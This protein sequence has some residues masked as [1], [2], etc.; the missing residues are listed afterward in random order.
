MTEI[1]FR[2]AE[3]TDREAILSLNA[4]AFGRR[5]E[6]DIV[7]RLEDGGDALLQLVA[8]MEGDVVG[9]ILFYAIRIDGRVCA[10]GLGP[11]SVNPWAQ[12]S[13]IGTA[14]VHYG[15]R[16]LQDGGVCVVF[17]LGHEAYYPRF[18][19]SELAAAPFSAPW[20]G[21][22]FMAVRLR[23]GPPVAGRLEF[24]AAFGV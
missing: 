9:H 22:H 16:T 12:R 20:K 15:L 4:S 11:M 6:A 13:G 8:V 10:A 2:T 5:D 18:G 19:F 24:P 3:M 14:L 17:V 23:H 7:V 21:P 1:T